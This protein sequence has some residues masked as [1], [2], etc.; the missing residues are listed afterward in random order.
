MNKFGSP[1]R[2]PGGKQKLA[3]FIAEILDSNYINGNYVEPYAGGGGVAFQ[4][5][6]H[7]KVER[8][9]L[10]DKDY[11]VF[12]FWTAVLQNNARFCDWVYNVNLNIEEWKTQRD[13]FRNQKDFSKFEVGASF[14]Y[15]NRCNRSGVLTGGVIGGLDQAGNYKMDARF[16]REELVR[17]IALIGSYKDQITIKNLDAIKYLK[18]YVSQLAKNTIV[19]LDPP[20]FVKGQHLYMN[21]YK[22]EDHV[23]LR[24]TLMEGIHQS[25]VLSYDAADE[26][27][28]MYNSLQHFTYGLRYSAAN[29]YIG[30]EAFF[31]SEDIHIPNSS[32]LNYI[33]LGLQEMLYD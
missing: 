8:I 26:I 33:N 30:S 20:Y 22:K 9:H 23:S 29:S 21:H 7:D 27:V 11:G 1:L 10:N 18:T 6:I 32:Q 12:C 19:Y 13:I 2:Y 25:W 14:F 15:L 17:R 31:F 3:P 24:N 5:L 4:L 16:N 28:Q